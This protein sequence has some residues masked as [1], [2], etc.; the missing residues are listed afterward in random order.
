MK[1]RRILAGILLTVGLSGL[2]DTYVNVKHKE[3]REG[4]KESQAI[5]EKNP[6]IGAKIDNKVYAQ[7]SEWAKNTR[8]KG[9]ILS[10]Y[11]NYVNFSEQDLV[12]NALGNRFVSERITDLIGIVQKRVTN[13]IH[14]GVSLEQR[15]KK[16]TEI[17]LKDQEYLRD[18]KIIYGF[19]ELQCRT[20]SITYAATYAV[21]AAV[22][23]SNITNDITFKV[24][25]GIYFD[26][27][28]APLG[29]GHQWVETLIGVQDLSV[30]NHIEGRSVPISSTH[31][32]INP[33][34][35]NMNATFHV[36]C[37]PLSIME[38]VKNLQEKSK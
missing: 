14:S 27:I 28:N 33:V 3:W 7:T 38:K 30:A 31:F 37:Y 26:P 20:K 22:N 23:Q 2:S 35:K 18:F 32:Y 11:P 15:T 5:I 9:Q 36:D 29:Y 8:K 25:T 6:I 16:D 4:Y 1:L 34:T 10:D 24:R 12:D 13:S 17:L 19:N 21:N